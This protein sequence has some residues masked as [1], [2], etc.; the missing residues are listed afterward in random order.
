MGLGW[1]GAAGL[2]GLAVAGSAW[3][4]E[5]DTVLDGAVVVRVRDVSGSAAKEYWVETVLKAEVAHLEAAL[6]DPDHFSG[7]MPHVK[8]SRTLRR[9]GERSVVYTRVEPPVGGSRDYVVEVDVLSRQASGGRFHQRWR[10]LPDLLPAR[11]GVVRLRVNEGSWD[12]APLP[13]GLSQ[14]TYRFRVDPGGWVPAFVSDL[15]NKKA[16]PEVL[17]AVE[18]EAQRRA[19]RRAARRAPGR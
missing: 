14:V 13:Q 8:E 12:I 3:A 6:C 19:E 2:L 1:G 7:F 5:W 17:R 16:I 9:S 4:G 18:R 11:S 15:A 10:A